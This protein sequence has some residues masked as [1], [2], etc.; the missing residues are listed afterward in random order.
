M[1]DRLKRTFDL[2]SASAVLL[3]VSP[4]MACIALWIK[5][6][7]TGPVLF[8]QQRIGRAQNPFEVLKFRTMVNRKP[9]EID[10]FA[11]A[12][13][14]GEADS[15]VTRAGRFLRRT[16]LDELPQLWNIVR[17]DMSVVG[18]RPIIPEQLAAI[19]AEYLSRFEVKPGLTGLSQIRGRRDLDWI[20][21]LEADCEYAAR[22]GFWYD[23][24]I[25]LKTV[26]V[27]FTGY[28]LYS[29]GKGRNWREFVVS[30]QP[31]T[32]DRAER[33]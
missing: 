11:E 14:S 1:K 32:G 23:L 26:K 15:R 5:L 9:E 31:A 19:R 6:D 13:V 18:P 21:W 17:G 2:L 22:Y 4:L 3:I 28:G 29:E 8:R 30:G 24:G 25:I 7:S 20:L 33:P 27:V 16:S 10:Q 12:V